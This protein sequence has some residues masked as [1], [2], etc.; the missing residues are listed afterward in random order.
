MADPRV[1]TESDI[2]RQAAD[3][4]AL[5]QGGAATA[6]D[7]R[8]LEAWKRADE[9]HAEAYEGM[10]ELWKDA[11]ELDEL[12]ELALSSDFGREG[13]TP[14]HAI[15]RQARRLLAPRTLAFG[16]VALAASVFVAAAVLEPAWLLPNQYATSVAET[17]LIDLPDGSTVELGPTSRIE[18][19]YSAAERRVALRRGEAFFEVRSSDARAFVVATGDAEVRVVGTKFNVRQGPAGVTVAVAE[20]EVE[21]RRTAKPDP[22]DTPTDKS[23]RLAA[24][25]Q[26]AVP[27]AG[28]ALSDIVETPVSNVGAWRTGHIHFNQATLRDVI[29]DANRYSKTPIVIADDSLLD[30]RLVAAFRADQ[31]DRM[32]DGLPEI[33]PLDVDRSVRGRIVLRAASRRAE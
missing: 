23:R 25:Q 9:R 6:D 12:R 4:F 28:A 16:V 17:R 24:G 3:W 19:A 14:L 2:E 22:V 29:A 10:V 13:A 11:G 33:L 26:V 30:L 15:K 20:G 27:V 18:V 32:I 5:L 7:R 8:A 1:K 31:V 21:V